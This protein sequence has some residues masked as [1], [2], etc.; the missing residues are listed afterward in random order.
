MVSRD[1]FRSSDA[2]AKLVSHRDESFEAV[3]GMAVFRPQLPDQ[4]APLAVQTGELV[5]PPLGP[6]ARDKCWRK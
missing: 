1:A 2:Q 6:V 3:L 5:T 4:I